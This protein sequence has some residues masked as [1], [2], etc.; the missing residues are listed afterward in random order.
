MSVQW[1][2][3]AAVDDAISEAPPGMALCI[4][5]G[6]GTGGLRAALHDMLKDHTQVH[7]LFFRGV[8]FP[9]SALL[10]L[11]TAADPRHAVGHTGHLQI[12]HRS[13]STQRCTMPL[14]VKRFELD[15]ASNGGCTLAF[16]T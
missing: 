13:P 10:R 1:Q 3:Q 2:A 16:L 5:H 14:Q 12:E 15:P 11:C 9:A 7:F 6:M 8:R 4:V